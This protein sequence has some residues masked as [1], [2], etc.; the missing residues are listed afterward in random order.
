MKPLSVFDAHVDSLQRSLD[1]GH[2]LGTET[3]G[4]LDLVRGR[5]GGL[6]AVVFVSWCDPKHIDG[7]GAR[8]RTTALLGEFHQLI[9]RH[10]D[11]VAWGGNAALVRAANDAGLVAGI[12]GIE[13]GHSIEESLDHLEWFFDRGVRV[14]TLVWNNHLS[15]VRSCQDGAGPEV[16]AGL[17]DLGRDV[18]R[19]MN[20]LGMVVDLSHT[21][22]RSFYDAIETSSAPV[23]ASHSGCKALHGHQRNLSDEQLRTL[24]DADG[25]V[26]IVFCTPFLDAE[27][28][29]LDR[30]GFKG[31]ACQA[32]AESGDDDTAVFVAQGDLLQ[33]TLPPLPLERVLDHV[34][35]AAEVAG[36]RHVG[37]GSDFD[38]ILRRPQGLEDASCYPTL[39]DGLA[40]RGFDPTEVDGILG[41][42]MHR[43]FA[44]ATGPGTR[45]HGADLTPIDQPN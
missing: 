33:R 25:V 21:G 20:A 9:T 6:G 45:A 30:E 15:W 1:L 39:A 18:V 36:P 41:G 5:R 34:V 29:R 14:M 26:G 4:H 17:S 2:D 35:H 40:R 11:Q 8:V 13:G 23:I 22:E 16:P 31:E 12:P 10:P 28:Q 42:N 37:I 27:A 19:R 43:V 38:G 32:L 7:V 3:P 24:R 44:R